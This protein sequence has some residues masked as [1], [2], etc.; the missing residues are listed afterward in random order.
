MALEYKNADD[1]PRILA[2]GAGE[3]AR[4]IIKIAADNGIPIQE[5]RELADLLAGL[6]TGA[7]ISPE[8]YRLAAEVMCFLYY[9]DRKWRA[10]HGFLEKVIGPP[11]LPADPDQNKA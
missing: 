3:V 2:R 9:S 6:D 7:F 11:A 10:E 4:Q 5:N 1:L 8:T